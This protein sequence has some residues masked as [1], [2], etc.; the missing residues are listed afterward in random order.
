MGKELK[1]FKAFLSMGGTARSVAT[2]P[3]EEECL[4]GPEWQKT[5][6]L[7]L[8]YQSQKSQQ[9]IIESTAHLEAYNHEIKSIE[10]SIKEQKQVAKEQSRN[11]KKK[12]KAAQKSKSTKKKIVLHVAA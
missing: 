8:K 5:W 6:L 10:E 4:L 3:P 12:K 1:R 11:V 9:A 7:A 2:F